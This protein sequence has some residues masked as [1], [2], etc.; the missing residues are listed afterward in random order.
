MSQIKNVTSLDAKIKSLE[1]QENIQIQALKSQKDSIAHNLAPAHLLKSAVSNMS[2]SHGKGGTSA[3]DI[4]SGLIV[5]FIGKKF[6]VGKSGGWF[7]KLTAP[8][9]QYFLTIFVKNKITKIREPKYKY[10]RLSD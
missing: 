2:V 7:K 5:G 3:L 10:E 1:I 9:I 8:V 4:I 6:W